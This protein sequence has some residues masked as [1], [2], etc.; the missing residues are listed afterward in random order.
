MSPGCSATGWRCV[1]GQH[2]TRQ[3]L[4]ERVLID[5]LAEGDILVTSVATGPSAAAAATGN[6]PF[7]PPRMGGGRR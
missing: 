6:N 1:L 7:A 5:T 4:P 2:C 3:R